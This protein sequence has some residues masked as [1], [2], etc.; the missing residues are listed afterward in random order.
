MFRVIF[1]GDGGTVGGMSETLIWIIVAIVVAV[2]IVV[3]ILVVV[4]NKR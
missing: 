1:A 4:G 3:G 2:L